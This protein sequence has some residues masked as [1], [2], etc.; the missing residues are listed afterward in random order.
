MTS[1]ALD[2]IQVGIPFPRQGHPLYEHQ[3]KPSP[4]YVRPGART[5]PTLPHAATSLI[6]YSTTTGW[7]ASTMNRPD[8][9]YT[10]SSSALSASLPVSNS[11]TATAQP[12]QQPPFPRKIKIKRIRKR[13]RS[14]KEKEK[15]R[16]EQ[17]KKRKNKNSQASPNPV[18]PAPSSPRNTLPAPPVTSIL[19]VYRNRSRPPVA[20]SRARLCT[21]SRTYR[22]PRSSVM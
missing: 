12:S 9:T 15:G 3:V 2:W 1:R 7:P 19:P 18:V 6:L 17:E 13:R 5:R 4:G 8:P 22:P 16:K 10:F 20:A 11:T 21:S 14:R